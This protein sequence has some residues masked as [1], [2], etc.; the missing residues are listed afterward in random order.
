MLFKIIWGNK[1]KMYGTIL[2]YLSNDRYPE[3]F[4]FY[5]KRCVIHLSD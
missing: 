5:P 3:L 4:K 2:F 1:L